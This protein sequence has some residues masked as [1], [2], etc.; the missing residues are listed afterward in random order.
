M[1]YRKEEAYKHALCMDLTQDE[2]RFSILD[3]KSKEEVYHEIISLRDFTKEELKAHLNHAL[4]DLDF[5]TYSLSA[6]TN[7]NT[8]IPAS[9]FNF[10]GLDDIFKLNYP[11][12][13][14]QLDYNRLAELS[15]VNI[16]EMPGWIKSLFV[17]RFPRIKI[18]HR[19]TVLLK[20]VFDQAI[21]KPKINLFVEGEQFYMLITERSKLIFFNRFDYKTIAD[22]VYYVLFVLEQ[23]ELDVNQYDLHLYGADQNW[24]VES[25]IQDFFEKKIELNA[26]HSLAKN[27]MLTK[28]LL[29]V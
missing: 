8:L 13:H 19:S 23:K 7:R 10:S 24:L 5:A 18:V 14:E 20:G 25:K 26:K 16:Y 27:F 29:C 12:P 9:L 2:F 11:L 1:N 3:P 17:V 6:G 28:Q 21:F 22:L 4:F 15:I